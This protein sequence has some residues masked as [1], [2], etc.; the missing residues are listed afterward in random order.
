MQNNAIEQYAVHTVYT[1]RSTYEDGPSCRT[2]S[3]SREESNSSDK[4]TSGDQNEEIEMNAENKNKNNDTTTV[5]NSEEEEPNF[6]R[7]DKDDVI[8]GLQKQLVENKGE[9]DVLN[10]RMNGFTLVMYQITNQLGS[11]KGNS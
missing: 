10:M 11:R 2:R 3:R 8:E 7:K 1:I 9:V 6:I 4:D 5:E